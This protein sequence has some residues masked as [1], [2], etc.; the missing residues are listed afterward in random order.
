MAGDN[1]DFSKIGS[2]KTDKRHADTFEGREDA[3]LE[4]EARGK[5]AKQYLRD[6]EIERKLAGFRPFRGGAPVDYAK[7]GMVK[8]KKSGVRGA[9]CA[10]RG[11]GKGKM[12]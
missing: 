2:G 7:G 4:G 6:R 1:I 9:G 12:Y 10:T 5:A 3:K 11:Q 8:A